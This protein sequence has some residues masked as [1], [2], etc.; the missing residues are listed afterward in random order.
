LIQVNA[1]LAFREHALAWAPARR[2]VM[3]HIYRVSFFKTLFD[4]TGHRADPCQGS[5]E[6]RAETRDDA[7]ENARHR[8]A[9]FKGITNWSFYADYEVV[10]ELPARKRIS[11]SVWRKSLGDHAL[12]D[13]TGRSFRQ[14]AWQR[15]ISA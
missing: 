5:M 4:S 12:N 10:E 6:V 13:R 15:I 8:F 11:R 2:K 3:A 9:E 14:K 7:V 1:A